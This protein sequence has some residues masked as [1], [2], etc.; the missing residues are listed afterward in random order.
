[1]G[2]TSGST[3]DVE[4]ERTGLEPERADEEGGLLL[5]ALG[6]RVPQIG[7]ADMVSEG[8]EPVMS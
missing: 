6:E 7:R 8:L 3:A 1:M 2:V 4:H 5:G